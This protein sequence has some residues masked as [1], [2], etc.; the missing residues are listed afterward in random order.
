MHVP[1]GILKSNQDLINI[2]SY[3]S[4][5]TLPKHVNFDSR[6]TEENCRTLESI[7][8]LS[9]TQALNKDVRLQDI[10]KQPEHVARVL[11][12]F[13]RGD[14]E[15]DPSSSPDDFLV[16]KILLEFP[17]FSLNEDYMRAL[18]NIVFMKIDCVKNILQ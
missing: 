1:R 10:E 18:A 11:K 9:S 16:D 8:S 3:E 2:Q 5:E 17:V 7:V 14:W 13:L 15:L 6:V 4:G 12:R